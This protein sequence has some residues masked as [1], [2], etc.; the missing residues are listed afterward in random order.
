MA[1]LLYAND[2]NDDFPDTLK[3]LQSSRID[4]KWIVDNVTYLGKGQKINYAPDTILA[5]DKTLLKEKDYTTVLLISSE[6]KVIAK[7]NLA[8]QGIDVE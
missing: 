5:Y 4:V 8:S 3:Q 7:K 6:V 2:N 1:L